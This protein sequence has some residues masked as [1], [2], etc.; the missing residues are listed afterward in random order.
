MYKADPHSPKSGGASATSLPPHLTT[1]LKRGVQA[2]KHMAELLEKHQQIVDDLLK[3]RRG[4]TGRESEEEI[5][6]NVGG[7]VLA[8]P[9][10]P[11]LLQSPPVRDSFIAHILLYYLDSLPKDSKG[12]PFLDADPVY[13]DWLFDELATAG[14]AELRGEKH[15]I[16]LVAPHDRDTSSL[17]Y[18]E[19]LFTNKTNIAKLLREYEEA[20]EEL[21]NA[22]TA[23]KERHVDT[24]GG[25][26]GGKSS[27]VIEMKTHQARAMD[28]LEALLEVEHGLKKFYR[29]ISPFLKTWSADENSV[30]SVRILTKTVST[31]EA[32][33]RLIGRDKHLY[34]AFHNN[35]SKI[36]KMS[37]ADLLKLVDFCRRQR[38]AAPGTAVKPPKTAGQLPNHAKIQGLTLGS[39]YG[40]L[41]WED[42]LQDI[43]EMAGKD[44]TVKATLVFKAT[45]DGFGYGTML[46][47][48]GPERYGLVLVLMEEGGTHR[49]G[50]FIDG[51]LVP[52][53]PQPQPQPQEEA[54]QG[55][56]NQGEANQEE[57]NQEEAKQ[58]E[59]NQEDDTEEQPQ[60]D[61]NN[62]NNTEMPA[63]AARE[64]QKEDDLMPYR[65]PVPLFLFSLSGAYDEPTKVDIP[66]EIQDISVSAPGSEL[67]RSGSPSVKAIDMDYSGNL[68]IA[69][70][71]LCD[72]QT[73][74]YIQHA[75]LSC[76]SLIY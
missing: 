48:V 17:F 33:L 36:G 31:T 60:A 5:E 29:T 71:N 45:R 16:E 66:Q 23:A 54:N 52:P 49:F 42:E 10:R 53:Q 51:P 24:K 56:A 68:S 12:R 46:G 28:A 70:G 35:E 7:R 64:L 32:T 74:L 27:P 2:T 72:R 41:M 39:A 58:E 13:M 59:A 50:C 40:P 75:Q 8:A 21:H 30:K 76:N 37:S 63:L 55:E 9:K 44:N 62:N 22:A 6:L 57:A 26:G 47:C 3:V 19:L 18:H 61:T 38:L 4:E 11:L 67:P 1:S 15:K 65:Y 73:L 34:T 69:R 14:A 25:P 43:I 20:E